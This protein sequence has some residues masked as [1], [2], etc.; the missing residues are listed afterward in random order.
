MQTFFSIL[1]GYLFGNL[2]SAYFIGKIVRKIDIREHGSKNAGASN[3][4]TTMGWKYG[5]L[6][7]LLDILKAVIPVFLINEFYG[8]ILLSFLCGTFVIIGHIFPFYLNFKGGKGIAS[9]IGFMISFDFKIGLIMI[10]V[11]VITTVIFNYIAIGSILL[12]TLLPISLL[13]FDYPKNVIYI[14]IIL[15]F[16]G[17]IKHFSNIKKIIRGEE[18]GL[19]DII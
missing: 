12:Y 6:T 14:S 4:T 5:I 7:G 13:Y 18:T 3:I 15:T 19:R 9:L 8:N 11:I 2:Q 1:I 17:Y 16:I 10:I